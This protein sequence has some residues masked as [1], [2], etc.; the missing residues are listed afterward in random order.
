M[1]YGTPAVE[2][3]TSVRD[4]CPFLAGHH[5]RVWCVRKD[6]ASRARFAIRCP[7]P[8]APGRR[9]VRPERVRNDPPM[10]LAH[11]GL[12]ASE[13]SPRTSRPSFPCSS[14]DECRSIGLCKIPT[15]P[16][17]R[18]PTTRLPSTREPCFS[19]KERMTAAATHKVES[20]ERQR[21]PSWSYTSPP[22]HPETRSRSLRVGLAPDLD[23]PVERILLSRPGFE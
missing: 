1:G 8:L 2:T 19:P 21:T 23:I 14:R 18:T 13:A 12:G 20:T 5:T 17:P 9:T 10:G 22:I 11:G 6:P 4:T 15:R 16:V 7:V 3:A